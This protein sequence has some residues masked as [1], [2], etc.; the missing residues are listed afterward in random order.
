MASILSLIGKHYSYYDSFNG[1]HIYF[2][3]TDVILENGDIS[4]LGINCWNQAVKRVMSPKTLERLANGEVIYES[5]VIDYCN[6][7]KEISIK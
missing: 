6:T 7:F 5:R 3:I 2:E 1:H 4:L